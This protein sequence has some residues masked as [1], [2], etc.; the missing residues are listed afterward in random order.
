MVAPSGV[1][2]QDGT[3]QGHFTTIPPVAIGEIP[4]KRSWKSGVLIPWLLA[5]GVPHGSVLFS[6][7]LNSYMKLLVEV[8]CVLWAAMPSVC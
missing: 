4:E 1:P 6:M 8:V 2:V 3:R 7:L 5:S